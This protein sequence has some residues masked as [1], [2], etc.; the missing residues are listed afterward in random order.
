MAKCGLIDQNVVWKCISPWNA[1][2]LNSEMSQQNY[3][4]A[5]LCGWQM[6]EKYHKMRFLRSRALFRIS[7]SIDFSSATRCLR[8][9]HKFSHDLARANRLKSMGKLGRIITAACRIFH[10][11][12]SLAKG[13]LVGFPCFVASA[14][15]FQL[16]RC[17][18][19]F[20]LFT[21][22]QR[23]KYKIK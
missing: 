15:N 5:A 22:R 2:D 6:R 7:P 10:L 14:T 18:Q 21:R 9:Y 3:R 16:V 23:T 19:R 4:F 13:V 17:R 11:N 12:F 1:C 20:D 8:Y